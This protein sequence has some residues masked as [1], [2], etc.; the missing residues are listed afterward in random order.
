MTEFKAPSEYCMKWD[1]NHPDYTN[2]SGSDF[3][4]LYEK[5]SECYSQWGDFYTYCNQDWDENC[6]K[7]DEEWYAQDIHWNQPV[8]V[9]DACW[10]SI[11]SGAD[12]KCK[13]SVNT[14]QAQCNGDGKYAGK[15]YAWTEDCTYWEENGM[16]VF[17]ALMLSDTEGR[18]QAAAG[19]DFKASGLGFGAGFAAAMVATVAY[20][21]CRR[22][23]AVSSVEEPLL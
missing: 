16:P 23:K 12:E 11:T 4:K 2:L 3:D 1:N 13:E 14:L 20:K 10:E 8:D 18:I 21:T 19:F 7:V 17:G 9:S 6:V 15:P 22:T 5:T